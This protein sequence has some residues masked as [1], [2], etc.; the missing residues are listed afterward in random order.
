MCDLI[1]TISYASD[2]DV[3]KGSKFRLALADFRRYG[4]STPNAKTIS[5]DEELEFA[6]KRMSGLV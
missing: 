5:C 2:N 1:E 6:I 3:F 4:Y